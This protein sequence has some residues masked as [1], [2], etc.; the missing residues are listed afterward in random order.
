MYICMDESQLLY[1]IKVLN[2]GSVD[3]MIMARRRQRMVDMSPMVVMVV[4]WLL[5]PG[6]V[7]G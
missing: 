3:Q 4:A 2:A 6:S 7:W 1:R 5:G